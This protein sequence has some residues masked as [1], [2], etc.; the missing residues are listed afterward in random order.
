MCNIVMNMGKAFLCAMMLSALALCPAVSVEA[1]NVTPTTFTFTLDEPCKTSAGVFKSDGTLIRTLWSKVRYYAP[2]TYSAVW[3]G[4]DDHSNICSAGAYTIK[5]LQHNTEY[6]WDGSIGNTSDHIG[7]GTV[8]SSSL[9]MHDMAF[10]GSNGYYTSGHVEMRIN[11]KN[12]NTNNPQCIL[13][14]WGGQGT[15][16]DRN[17]M[18]VATDGK[19]VYFGCP[20]SCSPSDST[21]A[22]FNTY[23]GFFE[24][25]TVSDLASATLANGVAIANSF[26]SYPNGVYVGTQPG[27]SGMSVQITNNYLAA[28]STADNSVYIFN[29]TTGASVLHFSANAPVGVAFSPDGT[30]WVTS[31]NSVCQYTNISTSPLLLKTINGFT[32]ALAVGVCPTNSNFILVADGGGG[33][34]LGSGS[35]QLKAF[36][37][38]GNSLWTYGLAGGY[39]TSGPAV[40]TNKFMFTYDWEGCEGTFIAFESDGS[41][42]VG[43]GGDHR[44]LH[45]FANQTVAPQ[46][47]EQI[48]YQPY[49]YQISVDQNNPSR[50]FNGYLEFSVDY[51][52]PL[53]NAWTL[54]NNWNPSPAQ[55]S[56]FPFSSTHG[57][58]EVTTLTN[59]RTYGLIANFCA[60]A[61]ETTPEVFELASNGLRLTGVFPDG[62]NTYDWVSLSTD[63]DA[64]VIHQDTSIWYEFPRTGFDSN[65]NPVYGSSIVIASATNSYYSTAPAPRC[66]GTGVERTSIT[67][68]NIVITFDQ[69]QNN[70]WH[71]G[72]VPVGGSDWLWEAS[73]ASTNGVLDGTGNYAVG[74]GLAYAASTSWAVDDQVIFGFNGEFY[75]GKGE[76]NQVM[77]FLG[78]GLFVGQFGQANVSQ[79]Q[80]NSFPLIAVAGN[81]ATPQIVKATNGDYYVYENDE[82][83][84]GPQRWHLVNARTIREQI[85]TGTLGITLA[86]TN[87]SYPFATA[88][89]GA[90]GNQGGSL[91][92]NAAPGATSYDIRYSLINGGPY[93]SLAGSTAGTSY[94]VSGLT[95]GTRYYFSVVAVIG[96]MEATPSEQVEIWPFDTS[97]TVVAVG[98]EKENDLYSP[99]T[100]VTNYVNQPSFVGIDHYAGTLNA[101]ELCYYGYGAMMNTATIG[102]QGFALFDFAG[103]GASVTN[104]AAGFALTNGSGWRDQAYVDRGFDTNGVLGSSYPYSAWV[105]NPIGSIAITVPDT[106][107]HYL[108]ACCPNLFA[109][110]QTFILTLTSANG[111][112]AQYSINDNPGYSDI[113][114][115]LF[116]GNVTLTM[117]ENGP[118]ATGLQAL[119]L[120]DA[121]VAGISSTPSPPLPPT[122]FHIVLP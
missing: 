17:W 1:V 25:F 30:L 29:K 32:N 3:D 69:S 112:S 84:H 31:S 104:L 110:S 97:Q 103:P 90:S 46:Y 114:Q 7:G 11:F 27:F 55:S 89:V 36:N 82:S 61:S 14:Q 59:G 116:K 56:C 94:S 12:F 93:Q 88:V 74:G 42:W 28:A 108:T 54:V 87:Q 75:E 13:N 19:L 45:F 63:G 121:N 4:F 78:D 37:A 18:S 79:Y 119:F 33:A 60:G 2:G 117:N 16:Y 53:S 40:T 80:P 73:P 71:L 85:G 65:N 34:N 57:L 58:R 26:D 98:E 49:S 39:F 62:T 101:R 38:S 105:G 43:D 102:T 64:Y 68:N 109:N 51:T 99:I 120:D 81:D 66:C 86:L 83:Q 48:M 5:L 72:G 77:H 115:F 6:V 21:L 35:Q 96:G 118:N 22:G 24:A 76:A 15:I 20:T 113:F 67:S 41:F 122:D 50:I 106:N 70:G 8:H 52:K 107:Y 91:S 44:S 100:H 92:W 95:N 111:T 10:F 9:T 23:P 47:L